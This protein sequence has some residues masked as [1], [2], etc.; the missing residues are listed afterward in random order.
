MLFATESVTASLGPSHP[1][2]PDSSRVLSGIEATV[3]STETLD[4][5]GSALAETASAFPVNGTAAGASFAPEAGSA[6]AYHER[7]M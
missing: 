6:D 5:R 2:G 1:A 7:T 4:E 3:I